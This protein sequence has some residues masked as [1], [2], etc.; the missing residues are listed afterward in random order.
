MGAFDK[1][2][3][4]GIGGIL[5][6][7]AALIAVLAN[8]SEIIQLFKGNEKTEKPSTSV[9]V[10]ETVEK[11]EAVIE[12]AEVE[13]NYAEVVEEVPPTEPQLSVVYL[14]SLKV[15]ESSVFY[16]DESEAVDTIGNKYIGHVMRI[17]HT[18]YIVDNECYAI[19]YIGGKYKTLSGRIA[20]SDNS[21]GDSSEQLYILTDDNVVYTTEEMG[22]IS[23]PIEFSVNVENC[24]WLKIDKVGGDIDFILADWKLEE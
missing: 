19:Y 3:A 6:G 17:G 10:V 5:T 22:R 15:T 11:E 14:D 24:Q 9:A 20:V 2:K 12:Q 16:N 4:F 23:V 21:H 7:V 18:G 1:K 13:E 8:I